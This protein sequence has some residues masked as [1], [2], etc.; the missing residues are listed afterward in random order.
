MKEVLTPEDKKILRFT[1][2]YLNS[3]GM[4]DGNLETEGFDSY[5]FPDLSTYDSSY[6]TTFSNNYTVEVPPKLYPIIDKILKVAGEKLDRIDIDCEDGEINYGRIDIDIDSQS[7]EIS[8]NFWYSYY[9]TGEYTSDTL[10]ASDNETIVEILQE[11]SPSS[12]GSDIMELKYNG[13]GDS[14][15]IEDR[16]ENSESVPSSVEDFCYRWLE[17]SYGGWEINEGSQG[18]FIFNL[19]DQTITLEHQS[20]YEETRTHTLYEEKFSK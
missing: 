10:D 20:N 2:R 9:D 18:Q 1:C 3:Y 11:I 14:G 8:V 19:K 4:K 15:Y 6:W 13:S 12:D 7:E 5:D 16:F 17:N